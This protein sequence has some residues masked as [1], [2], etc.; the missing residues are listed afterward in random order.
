MG[1]TPAHFTQD[2]RLGLVARDGVDHAVD[3]VVL[4]SFHIDFDE[5]RHVLQAQ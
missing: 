3:D 5:R 2:D 1:D 4:G